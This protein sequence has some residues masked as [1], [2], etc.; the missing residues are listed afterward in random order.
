FPL[1]ACAQGHA[2]PDCQPMPQTASAHFYSCHLDIRMH[3][4]GR[5]VAVEPVEQGVLDELRLRQHGCQ[6]CI[7]MP[8]GQHEAITVRP[9]RLMWTYLQGVEIERSENICG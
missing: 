2:D 3:S 5:L 9:L 1:D 6:G 4:Q 7:G 8:L